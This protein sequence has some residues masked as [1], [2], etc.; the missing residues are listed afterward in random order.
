[1]RFISSSLLATLLVLFASCGPS[2]SSSHQ[3]TPS[4]VPEAA[5]AEDW[6][7]EHGLPE[8]KC[9]KCNPELVDAFVEAGDWCAGHGFPESVCPSCNPVPP[10]AGAPPAGVEGRV[11]RL[12]E[13]ELER[14]TGIRVQ[15]AE[16]TSQVR[17]VRCAG[18]LEF[19]AD[20][21]ADVRALVPGLVRR[22]GVEL[23]S[24]VEPGDVLFELESTKVG[25]LQGALQAIDERIASAEANLARQRKLREA[26]IG[27]ARALEEARRELAAARAERTTARSTLRLAGAR[28]ARSSGRYALTAPIAGTVVRRPAVLGGRADA[29]TSLAT[30]VDTS[31][32]WLSCDVPEADAAAVALGQRLTA[33]VRGLD[34]AIV[35]PIVWLAAEVDART[36]TVTARAEVENPDG[37]LRAGMFADARVELPADETATAV[38]ADAIQRIED[39]EVVFVRT[40]AGV[41]EPRIVE[42]LGGE[43]PVRVSGRIHPGDDVVTT[44]AVLL[45]TEVMPGSIGAGCCEVESKE[46][47]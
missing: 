45:R 42:R 18:R 22:L 21:V 2:S 28:G 32:M 43:D 23:G 37:R 34:E 33:T 14:A 36:R 27:A 13:P 26:G 1:M 46:H 6:C 8:S 3:E 35:G 15:E 40:G 5:H 29:E 11:V 10:P 38:P 39:D 31:S 7:A 44:G 25:E 24:A 16:R 12:R 41:Y 17:S 19:N 47:E 4:P 20:A 9:T 30:I